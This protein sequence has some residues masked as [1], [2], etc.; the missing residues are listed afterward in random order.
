MLL[1]FKED[2]INSMVSKEKIGFRM[3]DLDFET[4]FYYLL[5]V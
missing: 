3:T 2:F 5:A 4:Q 1:T